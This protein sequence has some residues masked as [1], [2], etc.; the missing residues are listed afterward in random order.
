VTHYRDAAN[1]LL[2]YDPAANLP[3]EFRPLFVRD[4][5]RDQARIAQVDRLLNHGLPLEPGQL[6][7]LV[8]FLRALTDPRART[9]VRVPPGVPSG[10]PVD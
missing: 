7:D 1:G 5:T 9:P 4:P 6:A 10:L 2:A 3:P 8:E